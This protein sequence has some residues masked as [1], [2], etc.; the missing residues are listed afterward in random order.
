[1]CIFLHMNKLLLTFSVELGSKR[2]NPRFTK[3]RICELST[4]VIKIENHF[5]SIQFLKKIKLSDD[6]RKSHL[7]RT[8]FPITRAELEQSRKG[9]ERRRPRGLRPWQG[10]RG[11]A[12]AQAMRRE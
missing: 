3:S 12:A 5:I 6:N 7:N 2:S 11:G 4:I 8:L 1:M 10:R 9:E